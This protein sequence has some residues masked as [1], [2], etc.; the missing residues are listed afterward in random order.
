MGL[1]PEHLD[2]VRKL[3]ARYADEMGVDQSFERTEEINEHFTLP[4]NW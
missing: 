1:N 3:A 4:S 2:M